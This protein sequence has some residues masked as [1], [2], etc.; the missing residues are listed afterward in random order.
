MFKT[1]ILLFLISPAATMGKD[2]KNLE[3]LYEESARLRVNLNEIIKRDI[4]VKKKLSK[5]IGRIMGKISELMRNKDNYSPEEF[6]KRQA[7]LSAELEKL[8]KAH[9]KIPNYI[10]SGMYKKL[11]IID[12]KKQDFIH[13]GE[14]GSKQLIDTGR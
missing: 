7:A 6:I 13:T 10:N 4:Q 1:F 9:A 2:V 12:K 14:M 11:L 5:K 8:K 3:N